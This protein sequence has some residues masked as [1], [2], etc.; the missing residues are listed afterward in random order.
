MSDTP[1]AD[2]AAD[3]G[4][5]LTTCSQSDSCETLADIMDILKDL[6]E[7]M[8]PKGGR[9]REKLILEKPL[10]ATSNTAAR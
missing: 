1:N 7:D 10:I 2:K 3:S 6:M 8:K 5:C 9:L 4:L